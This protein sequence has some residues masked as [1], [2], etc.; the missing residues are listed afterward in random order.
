VE[1]NGGSLIAVHGRT[2]EQGYGGEADWGPIAEVKAAVSVPVL[3]NGDV[4]TPADIERMFRETGVDGVMIGRAAVSNPWIFSRLDRQDVP[5]QAVRDL[6]R[7]H[8]A[9]VLEFYGA[10]VGLVLFRKFA[11]RYMSLY[12]LS[13]EERTRLF[14]SREV[15]EFLSLIDELTVETPAATAGQNFWRPFQRS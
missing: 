9:A 12:P 4:R 11:S 3:G 6:I 5:P 10:K 1:E 8:L 15:D 14:N 7:E 13:R 2:R